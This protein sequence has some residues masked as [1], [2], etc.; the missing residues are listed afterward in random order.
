MS[1]IL[2]TGEDGAFSGDGLAE[3]IVVEGNADYSS[4][5]GVLFDKSQETL[6]YYPNGKTDAEYTVPA[7]VGIIGD[8]AFGGCKNIRVLSC[9]KAVQI[10]GHEQS[11]L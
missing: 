5:D 4:K 10:S 2:A 11:R 8:I 1:P 3:I 7:G 6:I 9:K